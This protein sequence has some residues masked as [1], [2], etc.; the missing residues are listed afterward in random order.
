MGGHKSALT[1]WHI[2][3]VVLKSSFALAQCTVDF[4]TS[5]VRIEAEA[6]KSIGDLK[7]AVMREA[8]GSKAIISGNGGS[9]LFEVNAPSRRLAF[10]ELVASLPDS[11]G[12]EAI[13]YKILLNGRVVTYPRAWNKGYRPHFLVLGGK[14]S[15]ANMLFLLLLQLERGPNNIAIS[16]PPNSKLDCI[17][18]HAALPAVIKVS[19]E[20][21]ERNF[22]FFPD[23]KPM[24]HF[25][26]SSD[27]GAE[28]SGEVFIVQLQLA[29]DSTGEANWSPDIRIVHTLTLFRRAM[30]IN[31]RASESTKVVLPLPTNS[32]GAMGIIMLL[33]RGDEL[34]P[35]YIA[36]VVVV[37]RRDV[38]KFYKDGIFM[39]SVG[40]A[41]TRELGL[42]PAYKRMG[43]DWFR[44]EIGWNVFEPQKGMWHWDELDRFFDACRKSKVY[45]MNLASH[46]PDWAKPK[47]DF[48]DIPYK[49]YTIKLDNAPGREFMG[50]WENAWETFLHRYKD[51]SPAINLW[52]EPWEGEG[53]SGWKSTGDHY[54]L[55]LKH[56]KLAR[57]RV[58]RAI[59]IVAADSS[60][61][62][63]WKIFA[64]NMDDHIEVISVHYERPQACQAFAMGRYY[65][66]E[67]WDT[68]TWVS[69]LGD[70]SLLR[71][72]LYQLALGATVVSPLHR[73]LLF[74]DDG[75]PTTTPAL[76]A[77]TARLLNGLRFCRVV[78]PERPPF[79][80]LFSDGKRSVAAVSTTLDEAPLAS[81]GG[82]RRQFA[83]SECI[84][85]IERHPSIRSFDMFGNEIKLRGD[86]RKLRLTVNAEPKFLE[87]YLSPKQFEALLSRA[88]YRGLRPVEIIVHQIGQPVNEHPHLIIELQNAHPVKLAGKLTVNADGLVLQPRE[89]TFSLAPVERRAFG[90]KVVS[91]I[92]GRSNCYPAKIAVATNMGTATLNEDLYVAVIRRGSITTD[93]DISDWK[94]IGAIPIMLTR[95]SSDIAL[96]KAWFPWEKFK[97]AAGGFSAEVAFAYDE[98]NFYMA[99]RVVDEKPNILQPLLAGKNLHRFQNPPGDY[100]YHQIGPI[101]GASGDLIQIALGRLEREW[102]SKYEVFPPTSPLYGFGHHMCSEYCYIVYPIEDDGA[103]V[104]RVRTPKFYYLHPLPIDYGFLARSCKV[105]G[106]KAVAKRVNGGYIYELALP[107]SELNA[108]DPAPRKRIKLSFLIQDGNMGSV[109]QFSEGKSL[110]MTTTMDFE[111]AWGSKWCAGTE[112]EFD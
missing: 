96:L 19:V 105:D 40:H 37:P 4:S 55:L 30:R 52:N 49:N 14:P 1:A 74:D 47:G 103:E 31:P 44:T 42:I 39:A 53:I 80:L 27:T 9:V 60:H 101:P 16:L 63:D 33:R 46:A 94:G 84:M 107:W 83:L 98:Q 65:G 68:E 48:I 12:L 85:E 38:S 36:N 106:S 41:G 64:A 43:V 73:D 3:M 75:F 69:W 90:F 77:A 56:L 50:D 22:V 92:N 91:A 95:A 51:V 86:R 25:A 54:R 109:L 71:R 70:A 45:V 97:E 87:A 5:A 111:P 23:E 62:T 61:N 93:G 7:I 21:D 112:F 99:A 102:R 26:I 11:L 10:L 18:L 57:D 67:V 78:H 108:I 66:K 35:I 79:V 13:R 81:S 100:V 76:V 32:F 89:I 29:D 17:T 15:M 104:M 34:L 28:L 110:C 24:L 2:A 82:F 72:I 20:R 59:K 88:I 58:D 8:S 6:C